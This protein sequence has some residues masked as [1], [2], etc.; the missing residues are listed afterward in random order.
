MRR[1]LAHAFDQLS[2]LSGNLL[3][4]V[5]WCLLLPARGR[6]S[7]GAD[8]A[9]LLVLVVGAAVFAY[10]YLL[11]LPPRSF[12]Q[13]GLNRFA[14]VVLLSLFTAYLLGRRADRAGGLLRWFVG[15]M[16]I[17]P[18]LLAVSA[19]WHL[20]VRLGIV[21]DVDPAGLE[22]I[23]VA[24]GI[25]VALRALA[26]LLEAARPRR[27]L[28]TG[29]VLWLHL[30][31]VDA[32]PAEPF[33]QH[34]APYA[35]PA[36]N[37]EA[38][39]HAQPA[40][41]AEALAGLARQRAGVTDLYFVGVAGDAEEEPLLH[42]VQFVRSLFDR[43]F[44]TAGRS[45]A[46]INHP[47]TVDRTPIA[48]AHNLRDVLH[49]LA[50]VMN[51]D[52]DVLFLF[53][54]SHGTADQELWIDFWPLWLNNLP[55]EELKSALDD[56][57]IKWRIIFISSCYSGG[58]IDALRDDF[59]LILSDAGS[60]GLSYFGDPGQ[61]S[62]FVDSY[63]DHALRDGFSFLDAYPLAV[64]QVRRLEREAGIADLSKP[65]MFVGSAIGAKLLQLERRL[66]GTASAGLVSD[67]PP[68]P[69]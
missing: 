36:V 69:Q 26:D 34:D 31:V 9:V 19:S 44:D 33:W 67:Q 30:R 51:P 41:V 59:S 7:G 52:E 13:P 10:D 4:G 1:F 42:D 20:L 23:V 15:G 6:L 32:L 27:F 62:M 61:L 47:S 38:T 48:D 50:K 45:L 40:L 68:V 18:P 21:G 49:G 60:D 54:S 16:A 55:A 5:R 11:A 29:M 39:F 35:P 53:L 14:A 12:N 65:Q 64:E 37:V 17:L 25:L 8:Q 2:A 43:R 22:A 56:A 58:F 46:L 28:A 57:G 3:V 66:R 24:W 63:F